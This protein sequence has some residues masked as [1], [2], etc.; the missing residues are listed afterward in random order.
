M[1]EPLLNKIAGLRPPALLKQNFSHNYF[2]VN[3][4][5]FLRTILLQYIFQRLT[6]QRIYSIVKQHAVNRQFSPQANKDENNSPSNA[7]TPNITK[8]KKNNHCTKKIRKLGFTWS[9]LSY[10]WLVNR[11]TWTCPRYPCLQSVNEYIQVRESPVLFVY[12]L[13]CQASSIVFHQ[14]R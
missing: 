9:F 8:T 5:N 11:N 10:F 4:A 13:V 2:P 7:F 14:T 12:I 3:F 6:L 1:P